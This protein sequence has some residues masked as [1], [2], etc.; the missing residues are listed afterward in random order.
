MSAG[1]S[2]TDNPILCN[3][4]G[5]ERLV[6]PPVCEWHIKQDDPECRLCPNRNT[7]TSKG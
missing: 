3:Y 1:A 6:R 7:S 5:T 2:V 4:K